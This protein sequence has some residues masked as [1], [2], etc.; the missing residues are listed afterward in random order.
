MPTTPVRSDVAGPRPALAE[1]RVKESTL[2]RVAQLAAAVVLVAAGIMVG[3]Y[4]NPELAATLVAAGIHSGV[5]AFVSGH[6]DRKHRKPPVRDC[7]P[8]LAFG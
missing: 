4:I 5:D 1:T 8:A 6:D 3:M 7:G 2:R